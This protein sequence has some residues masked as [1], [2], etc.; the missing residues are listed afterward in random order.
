MA[1]HCPWD[2]DQCLWCGLQGP[3]PPATLGFTAQLPSA[4]C[5]VAPLPSPTPDF[6]VC[7]PSSASGPLHMLLLLSEAF[8]CPFPQ[9][10]PTSPSVF[11]LKHD[12]LIE[13]LLISP[14]S[15]NKV[16]LRTP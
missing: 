10:V 12:L 3:A 6:L 5:T 4:R 7:F 9:L 1:S 8:P 11:Q 13:H 14:R 2:K 16:T 15:T